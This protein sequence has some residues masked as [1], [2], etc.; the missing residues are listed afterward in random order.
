MAASASSLL[1]RGAISTKAYNAVAKSTKHQRGKM[2][3]FHGKGS[4][5]QGSGRN[6]GAVECDEINEKANQ[7]KSAP[8]VKAPSGKSGAMRGGQPKAG[9]IDHEQGKK[10]P[11]G[12]SGKAGTPKPPS[13]IRGGVVPSG[14]SSYA[15]GGRNT[16]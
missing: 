8:G 6:S 7:A 15:G 14:G 2:A 4:K 13:K 5:D 1:R 12:V 9:H 11:G 3:P 16:Q 10:S